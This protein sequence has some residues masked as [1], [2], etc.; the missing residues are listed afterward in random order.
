M[1]VLPLAKVSCLELISRSNSKILGYTTCRSVVP[2]PQWKK[3]KK[4][5]KLK[6]K[7]ERKAAKKASKAG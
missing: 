7:S 2:A 4:E 5:E 3:K 1:L 6:Q